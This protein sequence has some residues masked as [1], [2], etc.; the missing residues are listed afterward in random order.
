[1]NKAYSG[2]TWENAP[3]TASP[4]DE[5]NLNAI[6]RGLSTVDDRVIDLD[7]RVSNCVKS[8]RYDERS[9][10]LLVTKEDDTEY[11]Y[12]VTSQILS[13]INDYQE[14][15]RVGFADVAT[16][17][18]SVSEMLSDMDMRIN[19][20]AEGAN[21]GMQ[22]I[23]TTITDFDGYYRR[24]M[25]GIRTNLDGLSD[26]IDHTD[27]ELTRYMSSITQTTEA[28]QLQVTA[29]T[30]NVGGIEGD[31]VT[32]QSQINQTATDLSMK[33]TKLQVI[34]DLEQEFGSGIH[35]AWNRITI[36]S[37]GAFV[38][39]TDNFKLDEEGNAEFKGAVFMDE[40]YV[41]G[42]PI[43]T[44]NDGGGSMAGVQHAHHAWKL[45]SAAMGE[46]DERYYT[47]MTANKHLIV[48]NNESGAVT[49]A[50]NVTGNCTVGSPNHPWKTG[51]FN[52]L[53]VCTIE[54]NDVVRHDVIPEGLELTLLASDWEQVD[55]GYPLFRMYKTINNIKPGKTFVSIA[56]NNY[57]SFRSVYPWRVEAACVGNNKVAFFCLGSMTF[58]NNPPAEDMNIIMLAEDYIMASA[59]DI[60]LDG[61][62]DS[63]NNRLTLTWDSMDDSSKFISFLGE[64]VVIEQYNESTDSWDEFTVF[65]ETGS[66][67]KNQ[68]S[69]DFLIIGEELNEG[70]GE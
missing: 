33:V 62:Y 28:I 38:V 15:V 61:S 35:I 36:A 54:N 14:Q 39:N 20:T 50:T 51:Y 70:G 7:T 22:D 46:N 8:V 55:S 68:F 58:P 10:K 42:Y 23:K 53:R 30:E 12:N 29:I 44:V 57:T 65:P 45:R 49:N 59:G 66:F 52:N 24:E 3:S 48:S 31:M 27:G 4:I 63:E 2:M 21:A 25:S 9:G 64:L 6:S 1:M 26:H 11:D 19:I 18:Q 13:S 17:F 56:V 60:E 69:D 40:G 43:M 47:Y 16:N 37:T 67:N 41:G 34:D 32:M 5:I